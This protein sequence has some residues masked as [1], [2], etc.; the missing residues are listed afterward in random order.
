MRT[1]SRTGNQPSLT[2]AV[3]V[4]Q[5]TTSVFLR[6]DGSLDFDSDKRGR[7]V[8]MGSELWARLNGVAGAEDANARNLT[9]LRQVG[10]RL[11]LGVAG[12]SAPK[13]LPAC[14]ASQPLTAAAS[15]APV[16][17]IQPKGS[18]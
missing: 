17:A 8:R 14:L 2:H 3:Q 1:D 10:D 18:C 4:I 7:A 13:Q 15:G 6:E 11:L 12:Q 9:A 16:Y 5:A